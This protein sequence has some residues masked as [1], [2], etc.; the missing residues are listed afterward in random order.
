MKNSFHVGDVGRRKQTYDRVRCGGSFVSLRYFVAIGSVS[1]VP[2]SI[3][4]RPR[5]EL[6]P[7]VDC[8]VFISFLLFALSF[9]SFADIGYI[10]HLRTR[11]NSGQHSS[12]RETQHS[13]YGNT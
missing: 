5:S 6:G 8:S 11:S 1:F 3:R 4:L 10:V 12:G 13:L 9:L 2:P 7:F